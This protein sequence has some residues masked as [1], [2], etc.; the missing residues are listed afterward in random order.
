MD[1]MERRLLYKGPPW[2]ALTRPVFQIEVKVDEDRRVQERIG[3]TWRET[4]PEQ[5]LSEIDKRIRV[6]QEDR[7][8]FEEFF[9]GTEVP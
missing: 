3:Y 7:K 2:Y 4:S 9:R 5:V 6:L 1:R 8:H